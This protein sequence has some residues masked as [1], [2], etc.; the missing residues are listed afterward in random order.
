MLAFVLILDVAPR[1]GLSPAA[2]SIL[3]VVAG[4]TFM[5]IHGVAT[6]GWRN[7]LAFIAITYVLSFAAEAVGVTTGLVF[8]QYHYSDHLGFKVFGVPPIVQ[9][10]YVSMGYAS[11]MMARVLLGMRRPRGWW[12]VPASVVGALL[13]VSWDVAMDPYLSTISGDWI[14]QQGGVYFGVPLHNYLGWFGT[15]LV[16][17]LVYY[18]YAQRWNERPQSVLASERWFWSG[19]AIYYGLMAL[20]LILKPVFGGIREPIAAPANYSGTLATLEGSLTLIAIFV[21]GTPVLL[22]LLRRDAGTL[23][24]A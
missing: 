23:E 15:V 2:D 22:A 6:L 8:G 13:M 17:M 1:F 11:M 12:L 10:A 18:L 24:N 5:L 19:P 14:W 16:F 21:M 20:N 9:L 7:I 3:L 4:F